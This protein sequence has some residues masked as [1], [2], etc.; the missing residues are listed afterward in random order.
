MCSDNRHG[1]RGYTSPDSARFDVI[2]SQ[3]LEA[4]DAA[5]LTRADRELLWR[6]LILNPAI[7]Y[8]L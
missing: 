3:W 5:G 4:A 1:R 8:E 6:T 7:D 2:E